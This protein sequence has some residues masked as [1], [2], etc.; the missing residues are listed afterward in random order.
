MTQF[1]KWNKL[2]QQAGCRINANK[3][4]YKCTIDQELVDAA[5]ACIGFLL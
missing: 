4:A 2:N 3:L 1:L 5:A